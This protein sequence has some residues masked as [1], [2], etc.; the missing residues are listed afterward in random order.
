MAAV[1]SP[2]TVTMPMEALGG[3]Q[4]AMKLPSAM[5]PQLHERAIGHH[6]AALL[7][8]PERA[9]EALALQTADC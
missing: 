6:Q 2:S 1:W 9:A 5:K 3:H 8:T 4:A 7:L